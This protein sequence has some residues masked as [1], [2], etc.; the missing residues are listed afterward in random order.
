[1]GRN[2]LV[3][4]D[5]ILESTFSSRLLELGAGN[6]IVRNFDDLLKRLKWR[7]WDCLVI[8]FSPSTHNQIEKFSSCMDTILKEDIP[9]VIVTDSHKNSLETRYSAAKQIAVITNSTSVVWFLRWL[10]EIQSNATVLKSNV[11][12]ESSNQEYSEAV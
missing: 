12:C 9:T 5:Q 10:T 4:S 1:M 6:C 8:K 11:Y 7:K 2:F 3:L